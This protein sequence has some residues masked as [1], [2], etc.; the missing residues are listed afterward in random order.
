MADPDL[1]K[2]QAV[3]ELFG[4]PTEARD[5]AWMERLYTNLPK[6]ARRVLAVRPPPRPEHI[7]RI[8]GRP[9]PSVTHPSGLAGPRHVLWPSP[10]PRNTAPD[11]LPRPE[12][13]TRKSEE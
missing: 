1:A 9:K 8:V 4:V 6:A 10:P 7:R 12:V 5:T 3:Q 2:T 11:R 13:P